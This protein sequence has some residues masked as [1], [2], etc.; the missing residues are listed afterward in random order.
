MD[1]TPALLRVLQSSCRLADGYGQGIRCNLFSFSNEI[2]AFPGGVRG[3]QTEGEFFISSN[4]LLL[5]V[6]PMAARWLDKR[7]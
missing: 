6:H 2:V 1:G 7:K 3:T 5:V 4:S